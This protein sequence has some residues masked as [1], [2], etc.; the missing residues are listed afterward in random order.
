MVVI[1]REDGILISLIPEALIC[2]CLH[3][4]TGSCLEPLFLLPGRRWRHVPFLASLAG[5]T[6][7]PMWADGNLE[8]VNWE[9]SG[10]G[11]FPLLKEDCG[12]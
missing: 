7:Y 6:H 4:R 9:T 5:R 8:K 11:L 2:Q 1:S 3:D 12:K 10:E